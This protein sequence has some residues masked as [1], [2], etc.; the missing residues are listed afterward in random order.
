MRTCLHGD[1]S[2]RKVVGGVGSIRRHFRHLEINFTNWR[3]RCDFEGLRLRG[4]CIA[5]REIRFETSIRIKL[6]PPRI[7]HWAQELVTAERDGC[8]NFFRQL[9]VAF[10]DGGLGGIESIVSVQDVVAE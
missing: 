3:V 7:V 6:D 8:L 10:V 1:C 4:C 5:A 9:A 2:D